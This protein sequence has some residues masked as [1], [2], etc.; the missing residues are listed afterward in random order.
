MWDVTGMAMVRFITI[1]KM[2]IPETI[3]TTE[4]ISNQAWRKVQQPHW[5]NVYRLTFLYQ[6]LSEE[7]TYNK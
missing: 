7:A 2:A 5:W 1:G 6:G 3:Q 4:V